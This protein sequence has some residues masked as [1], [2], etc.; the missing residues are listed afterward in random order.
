MILS[1]SNIPPDYD[2][3]NKLIQLVMKLIKCS[4]ILNSLDCRK[5]IIIPDCFWM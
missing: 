3:L 1:K 2:I 4:T 5:I